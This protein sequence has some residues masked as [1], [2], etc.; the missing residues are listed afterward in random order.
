MIDFQTPLAG[1]NR[2][3]AK[4]DR[5]AARIAMAP[6][7]SG[8]SVDLS[9]E[10]IALMDARNNFEANV[11]SFQAEDRMTRTLLDIAG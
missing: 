7:A 2:A 3:S 11:R 5:A 9:E 6:V 4:L 1:M 10:M 8:D